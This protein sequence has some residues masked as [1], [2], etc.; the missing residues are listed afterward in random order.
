MENVS[1]ESVSP[2]FQTGVSWN[3]WI[4]LF[5]MQKKRKS[6]KKVFV[7]VFKENPKFVFDGIYTV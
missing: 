4:E 2:E 1:K 5:I 3:M 6:K 7:S